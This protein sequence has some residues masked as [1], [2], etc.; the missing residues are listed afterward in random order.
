M[1]PLELTGMI[2]GIIVS[3]GTILS[4]FGLGTRWLVKHYFDDIKHELKPN[5]GSSL[6]DQVNRLEAQQIQA[7][8][9]R[10]EMNKKIDHM[11][12]VLLEYISKNSK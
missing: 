5:G 3:I 7:D 9:L 10:L 1:T 8:K 4:M 2:A 12:E 11:Y 6:K